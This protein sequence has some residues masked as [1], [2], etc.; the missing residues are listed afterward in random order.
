[1]DKELSYSLPSD[2]QIDSNELSHV[3]L[4]K[5]AMDADEVFVECFYEIAF[6]VKATGNSDFFNG[7]IFCR[8]HFTGTFD[9]IIV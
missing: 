4:V 3:A 6:I 2:S 9:S 8:K 1:M 7:N 5:G